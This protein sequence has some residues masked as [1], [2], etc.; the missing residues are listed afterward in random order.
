MPRIMCHHHA[1]SDSDR[2][3]ITKKVDRLRKF[4]ERIAEVSVILDAEKRVC[5]AELLVFGP[6]LNLRV[7]HSAEDM[8][9]AFE[10]AINK[11]AVRVKGFTEGKKGKVEFCVP[12]FSVVAVNEATEKQ[13]VA[14]DK[15][16]QEFFAAYFKRTRVEQAHPSERQQP[17][18]PSPQ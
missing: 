18:S 11:A 8:R 1:L 3:F 6:Q 14:L 13:A 17:D 16:L 4:F 5:V 12:V 9:T 2:E 10:E 15:E 7:R